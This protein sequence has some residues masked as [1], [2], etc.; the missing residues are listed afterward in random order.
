MNVATAF[1]GANRCWVLCGVHA[2]S[3]HMLTNDELVVLVIEHQQLQCYLSPRR[4]LHLRWNSRWPF[5]L[6]AAWRS[7]ELPQ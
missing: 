1:C 6:Q 5:I 3:M 7:A 2:T 4:L